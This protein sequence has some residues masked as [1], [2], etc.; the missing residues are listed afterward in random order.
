M[1]IVAIAAIKTFL[2]A[3]IA[4]IATTIYLKEMNQLNQEDQLLPKL[5]LD[6]KRFRVKECPCGKSNKDG[7]FVPYV[8]YEEKGYCHS[9]GGTFLPELPAYSQSDP[10]S[11]KRSKFKPGGFIQKKQPDSPSFTPKG[12]LVESLVDYAQNHF[13]S[14]LN[15]R[16]GKETTEEL[17][18]LYLIGTSNC[19]KGST[20]FWQID[21]EG[22]IRGGKITL[23]NPKNGKRVQKPFNHFNWMHSFLS[24]PGYKLEQCFFGEHLLKKNSKP[25]AIVESEKSA[26]I[27]SFYLPE[28][29]WL[30]SGGLEHLKQQKCNVLLGRHVVLFPDLAG[31]NKWQQLAT[32][33][34]GF[35]SIKVFDLLEK[36]ATEE[37]RNQKLDIADYLLKSPKAPVLPEP[38]ISNSYQDSVQDQPIVVPILHSGNTQKHFTGPGPEES[39]NWEEEIKEL[40][41]YFLNT[42]FP[43]K[44]IQLNQC[45]TITDI[46]KFVKSHLETV[47]RYNG[48]R[49]F[50]PYLERLR[51]LK[52]LAQI[53]G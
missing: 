8:G 36:G 27:G 51:Q 4:T 31:Y 24:L 9:C 38:I 13:V 6:K 43:L 25:V 22:K 21:I 39:E 30:A 11:S 18:N 16:F 12:I 7:K 44:P 52:K 40:E 42:P 20:V 28:F 10:I 17:I 29:I 53:T 49:S 1:A 50:L 14:F 45:S 5:E 41:A 35:A 34:T 37:E 19:W 47:K 33:L 46:G 32:E 48:K 3:T 15:S 26:I 23:Y 2:F